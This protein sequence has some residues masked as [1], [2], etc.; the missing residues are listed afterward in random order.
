VVPSDVRQFAAGV[1][2]TSSGHL[3]THLYNFS[4]R[5]YLRFLVAEFK[6]QNG[7]R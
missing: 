1:K 3:L 5:A 6:D 4:C 7:K 2:I